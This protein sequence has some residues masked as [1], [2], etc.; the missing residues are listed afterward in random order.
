MVKRNRHQIS[1][2]S[3]LESPIWKKSNSESVVEE[4]IQDVL[5]YEYYPSDRTF[6]L[7]SKYVYG[8]NM[9]DEPIKA[10]E[11]HKEELEGWEVLDI[12]NH[13][14]EGYY[15]VLYFNEPKGFLVLSHRGME[16]KISE[17][18]QNKSAKDDLSGVLTNY[19]TR[20]QTLAYNATRDAIDYAKKLGVENKLSF[21]G[22]ITGAWFAELSTFHCRYHLNLPNAQAV[23]FNSPGSLPMIEQMVSNGSKSIRNNNAIAGL[24]IREYLTAP[25]ILN[26]LNHHVGSLHLLLISAEE[27]KETEFLRWASNK[28]DI[29]DVETMRKLLKTLQGFDID[30]IINAF[31][32]ETGKPLNYKKVIDWPLITK[33]KSSSCVKDAI[34]K[35]V[36]IFNYLPSLLQYKVI[37][38]A[39]LINGNAFLCIDFFADILQQ[40]RKTYQLTGALERSDSQNGYEEKEGATNSQEFNSIC[41]SHFQTKRI[42]EYIEQININ[43]N[44]VYWYIKILKERANLIANDFNFTTPFKELVRVITAQYRVVRFENGLYNVISNLHFEVIF[45]QVR[46]LHELYKEELEEIEHHKINTTPIRNIV[47]FNEVFLNRAE[48]LNKLESKLSRR[49]MVAIV[50]I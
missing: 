9:F 34:K 32:P 16:Q 19:I 10:R 23:T 20:Q 41:V 31:S 50:G 42:D 14:K 36:P 24:R 6:A 43:T 25:S 49:N 46:R 37:K 27:S 15:G 29:K 33:G 18:F 26:C 22:Y 44:L 7:L 28:T 40:N 17:F 48:E 47:N 2:S 11:E 1:E 35:H 38:S 4:E 39:P 30:K 5:N 13:E 45:N 3:D 12:Y 21:T 8:E